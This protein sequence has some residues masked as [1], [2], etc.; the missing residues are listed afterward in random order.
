MSKPRKSAAVSKSPTPATLHVWRLVG[1][2]ATKYENERGGLEHGM[3]DL[4]SNVIEM[5][6]GSRPMRTRYI[7]SLKAN[8]IEREIDRCEA[9]YSY[10]EKDEIETLQ[11]ALRYA[12]SLVAEEF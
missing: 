1:A 9:S 2:I 7:A 10:E 12:E 4:A 6:D 8:R 3:W 11:N 5:L